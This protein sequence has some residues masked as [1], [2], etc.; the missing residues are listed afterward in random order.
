VKGFIEFIRK[1]N[2]VAIAVAFVLG[3]AFA[4]LVASFTTNFISPLLGLFGGTN[5]DDLYWCLQPAEGFPDCAV[6]PATGLRT[7][8]FI[9]YGA[10]FTVLISFLITAAVLYFFVV[11]PYSAFEERF[12]KGEEE[13]A[14]PTEIDLLT[15]I[16]DSLAT[17]PGGPSTSG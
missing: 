11:K 7:G 3:A 16:R 9:G 10:F 15:E 8:V 5:F 13:A 14:G 17:R 6:D 2:L 4:A 1:G 12:K